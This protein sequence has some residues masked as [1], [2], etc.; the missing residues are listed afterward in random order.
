MMAT[1]RGGRQGR[2][3]KEEKK[4]VQNRSFRRAVRQKLMEKLKTK[5]KPFKLWGPMPATPQN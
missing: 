4:T 5:M 2:Y 3:R 1:G